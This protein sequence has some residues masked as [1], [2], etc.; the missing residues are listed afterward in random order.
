MFYPPPGFA[1]PPY[2][3]GFPPHGMPPQYG[4]FPPQGHHPRP[5]GGRAPRPFQ[6]RT[7]VNPNIAK[8]EEAAD[9]EGENNE[10]AGGSENASAQSGSLN[11]NAQ[12]FAPRNPY[13]SSQMRPRFQNKT[14]VR[15]DV[16]KEEELSS[17]LPKTP[18]QESMES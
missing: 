3:M 11:P 9:A 15:Q 6:N 1:P 5:S 8:K 2:G 16:A 7:W 12:T 14:W 10:A 17:S 18:P 13:Y 4:Q